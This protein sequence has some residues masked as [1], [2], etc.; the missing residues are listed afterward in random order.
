MSMKHRARFLQLLVLATPLACQFQVETDDSN[1]SS[2]A[3]FGGSPTDPPAI[4]SGQPQAPSGGPPSGVD[5]FG[6][7]LVSEPSV[8]R[9]ASSASSGD[10]LSFRAISEWLIGD[11]ARTLPALRDWLGQWETV[12][13]VGT[14]DAPVATR[15]DVNPLLIAPWFRSTSPA[16]SEPPPPGTDGYHETTLPPASNGDPATWARAPF[17]LLAVVNRLDL[18]QDPCLGSAGELRFVYTALD[19]SLLLPLEMTV[20]VEVP[21]P[22]TRSAVAWAR[23]WHQLPPLGSGQYPMALAGLASTVLREAD[24]FA[25]RVRTN[26]VALGGNAGKPWELREFR[27]EDTEF[28]RR[29]IMTPLESTPREDVDPKSVAAH[30]VQNAEEISQ[31]PV[32]LPPALRAAAAH[33]SR[34]AF[35]WAVPGVEESL[36]NAFSRQTCNG[37]HGGDTATLPFQHIAADPTLT[38]S[39]R[40]SRFL[41]DPMAPSDEL[42]RRQ[43]QLEQLL[44]SSCPDESTNSPYDP[45][46]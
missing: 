11:R 27:L 23:A 37:C 2:D 26:E 3:N 18:G 33:T 28:G 24:P 16:P 46:R 8:L 21:Y 31:G 1:A 14:Y 40:L 30:V 5:P 38:S 36:R 9:A 41:W 15:P 43:R 19:A 20:I 32:P 12:T 10:A 35:T 44:A 4:P 29:L 42:R 34:A 17:R 25:A 13:K 22:T 45:A 39:P 7:L 6:E